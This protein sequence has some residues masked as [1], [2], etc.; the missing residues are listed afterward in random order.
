MKSA[1]EWTRAHTIGHSRSAKKAEAE[2][3]AARREAFLA[4]GGEIDVRDATGNRMIDGRALSVHASYSM[5]EKS[6]KGG[7]RAQQTMKAVKS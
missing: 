3:W 6:R 1:D 2:L 7:K 4:N 5:A